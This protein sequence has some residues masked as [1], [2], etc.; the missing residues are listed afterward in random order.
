MTQDMLG[1]TFCPDHFCLSSLLLGC[2]E[3]KFPSTMPSFLYILNSYLPES[4]RA[5]CPRK[6]T[7]GKMGQ[8]KPFLLEA[9]HSDI[10]DESLSKRGV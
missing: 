6:E 10:C 4:N 3:K 9:V 5:R 2:Q 8:R 1:M 7:L